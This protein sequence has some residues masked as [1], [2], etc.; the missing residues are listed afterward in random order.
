VKIVLSHPY[1]GAIHWWFGQLHGVGGEQALKKPRMGYYRTLYGD[2]DNSIDIALACLV[3]FD[4]IVLPAADAAFPG[5]Q[6]SRSRGVIADLALETDWEPWQEGHALSRTIEAQL[7]RDVV[8]RRVLSRIPKHARGMILADAIT[9]IILASQHKAPVICSPGRKALID[10]LVAIEVLPDTYV[11][12]ELTPQVSEGIRSGVASYVTT[13]GITFRTENL[14]SL[15][16]VKWHDRIRAYA[17]EFQRV[18]TSNVSDVRLNSLY[19]SIAAAWTTVDSNESMKSAFVATSR[20]FAIAGLVPGVGTVLGAIGVGADLSAAAIER[21]TE[22][23]RW[24]ELGPE[25]AR[26]QS[27]RPLEEELRRR[28]LL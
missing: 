23:L 28:G 17:T 8:I 18:L 6:E 12:R 10:R 7:Q 9:D 25:I 2:V 16:D 1:S 27:L 26:Y 22:Q 20:S 24:Y 13:A 11:S 14:A 21:R 3:I 19:E 15:V 5:I 4:E